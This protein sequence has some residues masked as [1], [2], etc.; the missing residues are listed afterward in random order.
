MIGMIK[1]LLGP[2]AGLRVVMRSDVPTRIALDLGTLVRSYGVMGWMQH[3]RQSHIL[4]EVEGPKSK[5]DALIRRLQQ[6]RF[7]DSPTVLEASWFPYTGH[8]IAFR[9]AL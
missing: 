8:Y 9:V 2:K 5:L 7:S 6:T 4:I 3:V 1:N